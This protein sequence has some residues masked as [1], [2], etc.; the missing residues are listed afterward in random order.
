MFKSLKLYLN[1]SINFE[2]LHASLVDLGYKRQERVLE[3]GDFA[4]RGGVL[5]I[6]PFTFELPIRIEFDNE[7]IQHIRSFNPDTGE[8]LWEHKIAIILPIKKPSSLKTHSFKEE[9]PL[10][11]FVDLNIGDYVVHNQ[12]GIGRFLGIEK[13]KSGAKSKDHLVIEYD[14]QEKLYVPTDAM[15]LVQKYIAFHVRKPKLFRL[16]GKEWQRIKEKTRKGIQKLAWELLSLQAMRLSSQGFSFSKDVDWQK[17]FEATFPFKETP[18]QVKATSEVKENMESTKPMDRLLCGDV[19]YGK[20]EVAMRA[21]FKAVMDN[22]QVAYL[23]PTTILAEQHY[24]NFSAR[25]KEFP[26]KVELLCRF[27]TQAEQKKIVEGLAG[28]SIDIVIGTH[29]LL[30]EDV[31]F[32]NLGLLIIDEEQRFGVKAKEK[33][34]QLRLSID[35][36]TLTATPIPRTLYMSL[37]GAKDLSVINTPPQN[38]LPIKTVVVEYDEDLIKQAILREIGRKGQIYYLHN[39]IHDIERVKDKLKNWLPSNIRFAIGHGQMPA[40]ILEKIM[41]DFLRGEIDC[42]VCTM[43]IESGLDIPNVNTI[44]VEDA[45]MFGLSDLHQLRGRVGRFNRN[46]YAYFMVRDKDVL[47]SPAK[48]RLNAIQEHTDL[49]AGFN[50]AMED[51][52]IRG[53][54]NLLGIEQHGFIAA[55]GFDLYCRLLKEAITGFKNAGVFNDKQN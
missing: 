51:L 38:R 21:A 23:V 6:F 11:N 3:E 29:R 14:R 27:K 36:L 13:I 48:K 42:L 16:G 26:V 30:S 50:I 10:S 24:Q 31:L 22:K 18:D 33:L 9:V 53:A 4:R 54:G 55:V 41:A 43:I 17:D 15:N 12:H 2:A 25:L 46:A 44:I 34:K 7:L 39:R 5:D 35:V 8:P 20:T 49:G 28:G 47:D 19:G 1:L 45:D 40:K 52:E 32:K 37:M